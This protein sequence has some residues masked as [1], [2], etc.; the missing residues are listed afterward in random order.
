MQ[1]LPTRV[2]SEVDTGIY[3]ALNKGL[4]S[5]LGDIIGFLH[6][7]DFFRSERSLELISE[8][9]LNPDVMIVY[10]DLEY[11][12]KS[13]SSVVKRRWV[14]G[15]YHKKSLE[16]GWMAPHP[17]VFARKSVFNSFRFNTDYRISADY[18]WMLRVFPK[19]EK[20]TVYLAAS[21]VCMQ[22]GGISNR[23]LRN[24]LLKMKEDYTIIRRNKVGGLLTLTCKNLRKIPQFFK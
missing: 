14:A 2:I 24:I 9:F 4:E 21:L 15:D 8:V 3:D 22:E 23:S 12:S 6:S 17:T 19:Y 5:A 13:A 10:G 7:D 11:V 16:R 1:F 18:D 20:Q